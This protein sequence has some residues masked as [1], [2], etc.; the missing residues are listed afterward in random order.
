M[1]K[2]EALEQIEEMKNAVDIAEKLCQKID[3]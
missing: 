1:N 2:Q 3:P